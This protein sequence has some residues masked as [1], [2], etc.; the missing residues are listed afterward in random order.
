MLLFSLPK[1]RTLFF[2][3]LFCVSRRRW[4][5]H[6]DPKG[7]AILHDSISPKRSQSP[8]WGWYLSQK[9]KINKYKNYGSL[10]IHQ[11]N[12]VLEIYHLGFMLVAHVYNT[13]YINI[14]MILTKIVENHLF[15][16]LK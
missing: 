4:A 2:E 6:A 5:T 1:I 9:S 8:K 14:K 3:L 12:T 10:D 15:V 11:C 7:G 13:M 16:I